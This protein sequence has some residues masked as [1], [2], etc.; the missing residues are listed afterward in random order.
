MGRPDDPRTGSPTE[1]L[2]HCQLSVRS[3]RVVCSCP[4][5]GEHW[6][7]RLKLCGSQGSIHAFIVQTAGTCN[8]MTKLCSELFDPRALTTSSKAMILPKTRHLH[9]NGVFQP[10]Q[11]PSRP[12][13]TLENLG[14][15][16]GPPTSDSRPL[17]EAGV[18]GDHRFVTPL[19]VPSLPTLLR[20]STT[21]CRS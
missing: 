15:E 16:A 6:T 4:F 20:A 7:L 11:S 1:D 21:F 13:Q 3:E 12:S 18:E 5:A 14:N 9:P 10:Y 19:N 17:S 2:Y 8:G